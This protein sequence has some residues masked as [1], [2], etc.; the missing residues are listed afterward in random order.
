MI[1]QETVPVVAREEIAPGTLV[2]GLR[3]P[4]LARESKPGQFLML[5]IPGGNLLW[6]RAYSIYHT[7]GETVY[8]LFKVIGRGT[9]LLAE[10]PVGAKVQVIGPL[11]NTFTPPGADEIS[12]LV[13]GGVGLPPLYFYAKMNRDRAERIRVFIGARDKDNVLL[14]KEFKQLGCQVEVS[15]D[16][17]SVGVKGLVSNI[18]ENSIRNNFKMKARLCIYS[19]GPNPMLKAVGKIGIEQGIRTELSLEEAMA[20]GLGVCLGCVVKTKCDGGQAYTRLCCDGPVLEADKI[21]WE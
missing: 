4:H 15:T 6:G 12:F 20:C 7:D 21:V 19:C 17:G 14:E 9:K 10:E 2:V 16:D 1:R 13:G 11:G 18:L 3:S 5:K 8:I